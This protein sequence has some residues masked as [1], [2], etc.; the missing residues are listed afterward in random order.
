MAPRQPDWVVYFLL[1][2]AGLTI[3]IVALSLGA[4]TP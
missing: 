2:A 4:A 1:L 3:A